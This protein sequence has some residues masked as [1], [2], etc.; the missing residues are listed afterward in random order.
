MPSIWPYP[1]LR[2]YDVWTHR[3]DSVPSMPSTWIN[4]YLYISMFSIGPLSLRYYA[5]WTNRFDSVPSMPSTWINRYLYISMF[6]IGPLSL[7]YYDVWTHRSCAARK[8]SRCHGPWW[9]GGDIRARWPPHH[10]CA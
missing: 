1:S 5:V 4:R 3:C 10:E 9:G 2:H 6:S 8:F 7:R